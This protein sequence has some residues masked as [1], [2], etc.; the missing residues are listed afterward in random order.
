MSLVA[1]QAMLHYANNTVDVRKCPNSNCSYSGILP[2][3]KCTDSLE[4]K[5]C[6]QKW[7]DV[8]NYTQFEKIS[9][10]FKDFF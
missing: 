1:D 4:C 8:S 7:R 10:Q 9:K 6:G 2:S 3:G 5:S